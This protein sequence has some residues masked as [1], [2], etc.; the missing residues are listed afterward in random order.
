VRIAAP[1]RI[2]AGRALDA[3]AE[4]V[5][6]PRITS[7]EDA[8]EAAGALRHSPAGLRGVAGG[9]RG[10]GYGLAF[11]P[12]ASDERTL[13]II[14]IEHPG[15]LAV[16]KEI[17]ALAAA[18][19]LFVGPNDL[20]YAMGIPGQLEHPDFRAAVETV[21]SAAEGAGKAAGIMVSGPEGVGPAAADGFR[22]IAVSSELGLL[23][24]AAQEVAAAARALS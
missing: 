10:H 21:V 18:D 6:F 17:A 24:R 1:E 9:H 15:A 7:I 13:G 22:M 20:S 11:D 12:A 4:G 2:R 3:G 19:V 5:M 14:Q 16:A 23:L 8:R